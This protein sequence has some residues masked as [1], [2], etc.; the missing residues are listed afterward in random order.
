MLFGAAALAGGV[1]AIAGG[2]GLIAMPALL[3]AGIPP[4]AA[5]ATNKLQGS[6][7]TFFA[8]R[9]FIRH[10]QVSVA[11][12][13]SWILG[14]FLGAVAGTALVLTLDV[15]QVGTI[16]PV[17][18]LGMALYYLLSPNLGEVDRARRVSPAVFAGLICPLLGFYDGFFGPGTG[19]FMA[20][21]CVTLMG[22][23]LTRATAHTKVL[24]FTS[25]LASL[26]Y[27]LAFGEVAWLAG[28]VMMAGQFAG[29]SLG[30]RLVIRQGARLV[31]PV[32][33]IMCVLMSARL[34]WRG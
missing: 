29:A 9:Y 19:S 26:G 16:L 8:A 4:Q 21:A 15:R 27:F 30:A 20:L 28:L 25:N 1:D 12:I 7:G 33:V 32:A 34:L 10:G 23:N 18:L 6:V 14:T 2:G 3:L 17:L 24:N 13:R 11:D 22:H 5:L 31:R